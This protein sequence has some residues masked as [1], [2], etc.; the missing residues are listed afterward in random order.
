MSE[1]ILVCHACQTEND[2]RLRTCANC[3]QPL[4]VVCPRCNT[5]NAITAE[6]CLAC[7][8]RNQI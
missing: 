3:G 6:E 4:I 2:A 7:G 1:D 8:Q 5:V